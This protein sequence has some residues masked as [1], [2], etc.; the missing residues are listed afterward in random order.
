[1]SLAEDIEKKVETIEAESSAEVVVCLHKTAGDYTDLDLIWSIIFGL[2]TLGYKIWSPHV[3]HPDWVLV[4]V[5]FSGVLGFGLSRWLGLRR[6]LL[7]EARIQ[8]ELERASITEFYNRGIHQTREHTGILVFVS[9]FE[10]KLKLVP[11]SGLRPRMSA[12]L[13]SGWSR[14]FGQASSETELLEH[15]NSQLEAFQGPFR[16]QCPRREDD[17]DELANELVEV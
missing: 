7:S 15:L 12:Q 2:V 4:N 3:F 6:I 13:W 10:R 11:D 8:R 1:M 16:R 5:V 17:I 9:R 14:K